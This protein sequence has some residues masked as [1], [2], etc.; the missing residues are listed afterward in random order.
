VSWDK[1]PTWGALS[2]ASL[3]ESRGLQLCPLSPCFHSN[4]FLL[5]PAYNLMKHQEGT[6]S[7][8]LREKHLKVTL[9]NG[10]K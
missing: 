2:E 10:R 3:K 1:A 4:A 6:A 8:S 7:I 5:A 9:A